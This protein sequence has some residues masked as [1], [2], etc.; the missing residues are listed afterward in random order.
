VLY[1]VCHHKGNIDTTKDSEI[2]AVDALTS[3]NEVGVVVDTVGQPALTKA[4]V[5]KPGRGGRLVFIAAARSGPTQLR[6]EMLT[7]IE[8]RRF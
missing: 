8:R 6:I 3:A 1:A 5:A 2:G 7:F 4:I